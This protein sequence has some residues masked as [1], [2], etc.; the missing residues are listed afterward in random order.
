MFNSHTK[1]WLFFLILS[2]GSGIADSGFA[3]GLTRD[4]R[5]PHYLNYQGQPILLITSAEHYGAVINLDFDYKK[6]LA[7]LHNEGMNYTRIF[8]GSYVEVPGSFG[9]AHNTLS[10]APGRFLAPWQRV[11][12]AG[13]F[14]GEGKFDLDRWNKDYFDRLHDFIAVANSLNIIVEV[15]FFCA[16]YQDAY[17]LRHPF[18]PANNINDLG[19]L[20]RQDFN[21]LKNKKAVYYQK[22]LV[23]KLTAEL[24]NY[25]NIFFELCNEPWADNGDQVTFLH[26]TLIPRENTLGWLL[27]ATAATSETLSWQD[28]LTSVFRKA[29]EQ[30]ENKHLLAQNYSNFVEILTSVNNGIDILNFHYAWPES[31]IRNYGWNRPVSFDESGFAGT[32]DT[33]YL[34]EAWAFMLSGG[35]IFNGL[36]Y[37]FYPGKEDGTGINEAPGGGSTRFRR[38]LKFLR[39]FL[40]SFNFIDMA[41][42]NPLLIHCPGMETFCL[43]KPGEYYAIYAQ[44]RNQKK[45]FVDLPEGSYELK[46]YNPDDGTLLSES[47]IDGEENLPLDIP[48]K[49]RLAISI[50]KHP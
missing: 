15:T 6:Y 40:N 25:D 37:S 11:D 17:W 8:T 13:L 2:L 18:N 1:L 34:Q 21:T 4:Q 26:K 9:I 33:T 45:I 5:N 35:A 23:R 43:T 3:Q 36:D 48:D 41:P 31:V 38:Q 28:T 49:R 50:R 42:A 27:W 30:L 20:S 7:T 44:G 47:Q 19:S 12:E 29:E 24:N 32:H 46:I 14:E 22:E 10:P 16:T 39:E